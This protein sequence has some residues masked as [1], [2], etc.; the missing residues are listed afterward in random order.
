M[1][2]LLCGLFLMAFTPITA[3][4]DDQDKTDREFKNIYETGQGRNFTVLNSTPN[5]ND[6]EDGEVVI[7]SSTS[8]T[9]LMFRMGQ[10]IYAV[11]VS[12]VT[13]RG[14]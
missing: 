13:V 10:E 9:K 12:C 3:G 7:V 1:R 6:I 11:N 2:W 4:H 14:R 5:L 8:Y